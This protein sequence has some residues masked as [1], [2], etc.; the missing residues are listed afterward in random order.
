MNGREEFDWQRMRQE[1]ETYRAVTERPPLPLAQVAAAALER[2]RRQ[3]KPRPRKIP[4]T[5]A[6]GAS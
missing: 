5:P 1:E 3:A 6:K 2:A 4:L